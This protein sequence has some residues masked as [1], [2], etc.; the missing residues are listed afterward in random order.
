MD[1]VSIKRVHFSGQEL[2]AINRKMGKGGTKDLLRDKQ[3]GS[4]FL[5][6]AKAGRNG[7][8]R[9][10]ASA[11]WQGEYG[12]F[13]R[14]YGGMCMEAGRRVWAND[15]EGKEQCLERCRADC[16]QRSNVSIAKMRP[17]REGRSAAWTRGRRPKR[18]GFNL[19]VRFDRQRALPFLSPFE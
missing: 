18:Y 6:D 8:D 15:G 3:C 17:S 4:P 1:G 2:R 16:N 10:G 7:W 14:G 9:S 12:D 11:D 5:M 13:I 19:S